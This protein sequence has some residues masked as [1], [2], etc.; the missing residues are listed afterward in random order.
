MG[1]GLEMVDALFG[2]DAH[3]GAQMLFRM[4][5][6]HIIL[7]GLR[8][9]LAGKAGKALVLQREIQR[10]QPVRPFRMSLGNLV[11]E[12]NRVFVQNRRHEPRSPEAAGAAAKAALPSG[13]RALTVSRP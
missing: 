7:V 6:Q 8:G 13:F 9:L 1:V 11:F 3:H 2:N 10:L 5:E 4:G 12:E